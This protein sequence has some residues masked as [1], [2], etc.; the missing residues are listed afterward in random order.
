MDNTGAMAGML[1]MLVATFGKELRDTKPK[2]NVSQFMYD[3]ILTIFV[4]SDDMEFMNEITQK[5]F[6]GLANS[7]P[8]EI[9][10]RFNK[11]TEAY[12]KFIKENR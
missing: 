5:A 1:K 12:I 7:H 4:V 8:E 3:N 9:L 10:R 2:N 11:F 6:T